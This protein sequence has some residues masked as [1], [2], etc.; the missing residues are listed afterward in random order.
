M[1]P[2]R[3]S[4]LALALMVGTGTLAAASL[5]VLAVRGVRDAVRGARLDPWRAAMLERAA[6]HLSRATLY[7]WTGGRGNPDDYGV[8]CSGLVIDC[9]RAAGFDNVPQTADL[10]L[11]KLPEVTSPGPADVALYGSPLHASHA[12]LVDEYFASEGRA[13][14]YGAEGDGGPIGGGPSVTTPAAAIEARAWVRHGLD[15]R[16]RQGFLGF[17]TLSNLARAA[18]K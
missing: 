3:A 16:V 1:T 6:W 8:D 2:A 13:S 9:A 11:Q 18:G 17:R 7:Q 10:M 12:R 5:G 14:W 15:H 4:A